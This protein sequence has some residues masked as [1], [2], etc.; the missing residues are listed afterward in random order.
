MFKVKC[1]CCLEK[2]SVFELRIYQRNI[3]CYECKSFL[4]Y[5]Q[6]FL[7]PRNA[8]FDCGYCGMSL[9]PGNI[10]DECWE[11]MEKRGVVQ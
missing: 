8:N 9:N 10:C 1:K 2:V 5:H 11:Q 7:K 3:I 4:V 6:P